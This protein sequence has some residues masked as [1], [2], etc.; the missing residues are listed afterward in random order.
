MKRDSDEND[1][2]VANVNISGF[3]GVDF[4]IVEFGYGDE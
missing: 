3:V 1:E 2:Q 4:N